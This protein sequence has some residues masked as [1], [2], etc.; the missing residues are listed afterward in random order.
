VYKDALLDVQFRG[1]GEAVSMILNGEELRSTLQ[2]PEDRLSKGRNTLVIEMHDETPASNQ[3][4]AS[5]VQLL[6]L[7]DG[8]H[9]VYEIKAHGKNVLTFKNLTGSVSV[10]T[11]D[12]VVIAYEKTDMDI[13][14]YVEF[15]G[16]GE[17]RVRIMD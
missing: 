12:D 7:K 1:D 16:R 3:L 10:S 2:L 9:P 5:T 13:F 4:V 8:E 17:F 14:T 6:S 11:E 15:T